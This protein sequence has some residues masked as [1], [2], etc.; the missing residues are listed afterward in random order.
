MDCWPERSDEIREVAS[1]ATSGTGSVIT[2]EILARRWFI[3]MDTVHRTLKVMTQ[4]GIWK[5]LHLMERHVKTR[6][7]HFHFLTVNW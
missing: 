5:F 7:M 3:G 1:M 6:K 2:K 4:A